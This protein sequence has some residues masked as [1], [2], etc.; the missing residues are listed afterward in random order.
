MKR[1]KIIV[2]YDGTNYYGWQI[3]PN[4]ITIEE[5][6]NKTL[7]KLMD[8]EIKVIGASRTDSGVH[9]LGNVAV[10]D[11]GTTIP[12]DKIMYALNQK[13]PK[14]I[15]ITDSS[16][17]PLDWHPRFRKSVKTYEY[18]IQM[19]RVPDPTKRFTHCFTSHPLDVDKMREALSYFV[20]EHDFA[21]FTRRE[22]LKKNTVRRIYKAELKQE[23]NVLVFEIQGNGFL[24]NMVRMIVGLV[25]HVGR[26]SCSPIVIK[27]RL[28]AGRNRLGG[29]AEESELGEDVSGS[30]FDED[31]G[32]SG[33]GE[34]IKEGEIG[35]KGKGREDEYIRITAPAQ[36]LILK[37]INYDVQY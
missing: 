13:L 37:N 8:E 26:G 30:E 36:G 12:A 14:D 5:V 2:S 9:A 34:N 1:I 35:N 3:Q 6:L 7:S 22:C 15:V 32:G 24:Y 23:G 21:E 27:E 10:F 33:F 20:G 18:Y 16:E 28:E 11:T 17:V 31:I 25:M 4:G 29:N 19:G